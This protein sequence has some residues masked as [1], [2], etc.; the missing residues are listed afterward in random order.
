MF[1]NLLIYSNLLFGFL[2]VL[3]GYSVYFNPASLWFPAFYGL[4]YPFLLIINL[5][6]IFF[7]ILWFSKKRYSLFSLVAILLTWGSFSGLLN[8]SIPVRNADDISVMTWN[9][10]NFD[11]YNWSNNVETHELMMQLLE[12]A[13]PDVLCLQE[14]YT[15][16]DGKFRNIA[17]IKNRLGFK[18]HYFGETFSTTKGTK[19]WGLA[20]FSKFPIKEHGT[21]KLDDVSRLNACIYTDIA[22]TEDSV[23]RIYNLHLQSLHF[24]DEDYK[25][26]MELKDD[27][28]PDV[29]GS[30]KILKKI[31]RGFEKRSSHVEL[32]KSKVESF[33]GRKIICGDFNDT[34]TSYA[35]HTLSKNLKDSFKEKGI[36]FG[37]TLVNPTPFFRI[38]FM[39]VDK[40]IKVNSYETTYREYSDHYPVK[41]HLEF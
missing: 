16:T 40:S 24:A 22:Y 11:L 20:T 34:S 4:G 31:R 36:G 41:V 6:F 8:F 17:E 2:L 13:Q 26:F 30:K 37:N 3:S 12:E 33:N 10:K 25:Y 39:L 1:K 18:Y 15:E 19:K 38:D 21:I 7:W 35:Y 32:I 5:G 14:F 9:V 23:F 29:E 28:K 27:K